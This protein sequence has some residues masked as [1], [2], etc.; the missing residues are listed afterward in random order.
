MD[1]S[2]T[3]DLFLHSMQDTVANH[4]PVK[5]VTDKGTEE[6]TL[7]RFVAEQA[8]NIDNSEDKIYSLRFFIKRKEDGK[9]YERQFIIP[10]KEFRIELIETGKDKVVFEITKNKERVFTIGLFNSDKAAEITLLS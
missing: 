2:I 7:E 6:C 1:K 9:K 5:L 10:Q 3:S 4:F 8:V